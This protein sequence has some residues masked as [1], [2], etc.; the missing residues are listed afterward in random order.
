MSETVDRTPDDAPDDASKTGGTPGA[1]TPDDAGDDKGELIAN[2]Q[3]KAADYNRDVTA[4]DQRIAEL[5]AELDRNRAG[6]SQPPTP[7]AANA[8]DREMEVVRR[9]QARIDAAAND[10]NH[11]E[12]EAALYERAR[13]RATFERL[14][15][16]KTDMQFD[17]MPEAERDLA[18]KE[19]ETQNYRTPEAAR[20]AA[21]GSLSDE[22][23]E[24]IRPKTAKRE[25]PT[26][27]R[28][29]VVETSTR[30]LSAVGVQQRQLKRG[31]W[32]REFD[33]A[34]AA[35]DQKRIDEL[36]RAYPR[37]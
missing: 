25:P 20:K 3:R 35:G 5:E 27:E 4:R 37:Q 19:W 36:R 24:K 33:K 18:R 29:E 6:G 1:G 8:V 23:R 7:G 31:E 28:E 21:I 15:E 2:L 26:R 22:E 13:N 14:Q 34:T 16:I 9:M 17:A 30:P 12:H 32:E 10:P 11:P